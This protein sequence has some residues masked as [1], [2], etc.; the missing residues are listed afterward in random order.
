VGD[1]A[2]W[3]TVGRDDPA[4]HYRTLYDGDDPADAMAAWS[5]AVTGGAEYVMLEALRKDDAKPEDAA[6][7]GT[8]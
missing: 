5:E 6:E 4:D 1:R 3:I 8:P 7:A 2:Y